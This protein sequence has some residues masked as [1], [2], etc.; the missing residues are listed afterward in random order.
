MKNLAI[1]LLLD[2]SFASLIEHP[3]RQEIVDEIKSKT[4]KWRPREII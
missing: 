3:V 1:V 2:S 4:T